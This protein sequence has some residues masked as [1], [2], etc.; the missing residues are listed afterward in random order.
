MVPTGGNTNDHDSE[1]DVVTWVPAEEAVARLTYDN[2]ANVVRKAIAL[3]QG[4]AA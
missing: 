1:Y 4:E 2:E 3:V